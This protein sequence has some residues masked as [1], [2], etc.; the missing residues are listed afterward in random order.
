MTYSLTWLPKVLRDAGLTVV[1]IA[2]WQTR[3]HGDMGP[4]KFVICHHT[5]EPIDANTEPAMAILINGRAAVKA[6]QKTKAAK[7]LPGPLCNL[8]LGQ[9]GTFYMVAAGEAWHAGQG[10]WAGF[11]NGNGSSI[12]IE[13]ENNGLGEP[14]PEIQMDAYAK[15]CAAI[16][17][18][19]KAGPDMVCG[20]KE[21]ALPK[22]RKPD[23]SFDM[24]LFRQR[25]AKF[26]APKPLKITP[27]AAPAMKPAV[28]TPAPAKPMPASPIAAAVPSKPPAPTPVAPQQA[29][30]PLPTSPMGADV[31]AASIVTTLKAFSFWAWLLSLFTKKG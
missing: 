22:G 23:P 26:M 13:A 25:V 2:G 11:T 27:P 8:A 14:W 9:S 17:K 21:Y 3:G 6:T 31:T 30:P 20:H 18:Y 7:A 15:G 12:G 19:I 24:N 10:N 28:M 4:V 1:E 29:P 16:L 5:A